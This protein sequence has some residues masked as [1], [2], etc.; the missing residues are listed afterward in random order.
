[1]S[2]TPNETNYKPAIGKLDDFADD[3]L[4]ARIKEI[5]EMTQEENEAA[6]A[7]VTAE[8]RARDAAIK[9]RR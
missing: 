5:F 4:R 1:M 8:M 6:L 2:A 9:S 7:K 3:A